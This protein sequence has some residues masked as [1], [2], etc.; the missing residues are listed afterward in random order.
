MD[1]KDAVLQLM[2]KNRRIHQG[3][4]YTVPSPQTYPYQWLWDSCFHAIILT[5]F[6]IED[7]KKELLSAVSKQFNNGMIPHMLYWDKN[8]KNDFPVIEWGKPDTSTITQ[9]PLIAYAAWRIYQID[10]DKKFLAQIYPFLKKYH[11]FLIAERRPR[12][13]YL[14]GIINPDESGE[15]NS[16]RFDRL[17][18][19]SAVQSLDVNF[20]KR[21]LLIE[22]QKQIE[23]EGPESMKDFFWIKDVPFN[24][25]AINGL[26][27]LSLI[28]R[29]LSLLSE[30]EYFQNQANL[31]KVSMRELMFEDGIFWSVY[32]EDYQKIKVKTWAIFVPMFAKLYTDKEVKHLVDSLLLNKNS[33]Y[34]K[35]LV[36]TVGKDE[37]SYDPDGPIRGVAAMLSTHLSWRGPVWM[38]VNWFVYQGLINYGYHDLAKKIYQD[39]LTLIDRSGFRELYNPET[40]EG[41]GA[42]DFTWGGLV[43]DMVS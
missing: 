7:A 43:L 5:H 8:S 36:P 15:D 12:R 26:E 17:L 22:K 21:M 33:F 41:M 23:F 32:G 25:I 30:S 42:Q 13:S 39:S 14:Y 35:Y 1:I 18:G 3:F 37:A 29:E 38:G 27:H 34:P 16:P 28:A 6:N 10:K 11:Q 20:S 9:P 4:Q 19:L 24:V 40:G 2:Q 31:T